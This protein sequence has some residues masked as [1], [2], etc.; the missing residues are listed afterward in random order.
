M[1]TSQYILQIV[2]K[3]FNTKKV[4]NND[5]VIFQNPTLEDIKT[6]VHQTISYYPEIRFII[7]AK[8]QSVYIWDARLSNHNDIFTSVG[9]D[10]WS[11]DS[12]PSILFG[13]SSIKNNRLELDSSEWRNLFYYP[14]LWSSSQSE[15][16]INQ[17]RK[18]LAE[19]F[20]FNWSFV[21]KCFP[22]FLSQL[23]KLKKEVKIA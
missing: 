8:K 23:T 9:L 17:Y 11:R 12:N 3:Y 4:Y 19:F 2:E 22:G 10:W 13:T 14:I 20:S 18:L 16:N 21:E 15:Y 6:I 1:L 7:D 5:V